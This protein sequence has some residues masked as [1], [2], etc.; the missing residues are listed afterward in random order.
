MLFGLANA[1]STFQ[2]LMQRVLQGLIPE[3]CLDYVDDILV[4]GK[5]F[6]E[7]LQ[8]FRD[9]FTRL[10]DAGLHLKPS[11]CALAQTKVTYLGF[12]V[13]SEG[14]RTDARKVSAVRE[15]PVPANVTQLRSFLGLASYYRQFIEGYATIAK[16]LHSLTGKSC[17]SVGHSNAKKR[18]WN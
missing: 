10:R 6:A 16:P 1:P 8:N 15:F 3:K 7:H 5:T 17:H 12:V 14:V 2:R 11:K 13:S 4:L 9:V 18:S